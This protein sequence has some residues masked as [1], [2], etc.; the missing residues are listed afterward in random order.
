MKLHNLVRTLFLAVLVAAPAACSH[1]TVPST[2]FAPSASHVAGLHAR[3]TRAAQ[4]PNTAS[5]VHL[6]MV[7]NYSLKNVNAETGVVD[8]V[9]G[10]QYAAKPKS[11]YNTAYIPYSVD[12]YTH[13]VS[14]YRQNHPDWLEYKCDRKSP[15]FE[16]G[17]NN[18]P[19]DFTNPAVQAYQYQT[20]VDPQLAEGYG[21]IAIDTISLTNDWKQCGHFST[22]GAWVAQFTGGENDA[23]FRSAILSWEA[24]IYAHVHAQS[25]TATM[26]VNYS[27]EGGVSR[28][29]NL[30]L[31]TTTDMVFDERGFTNWGAKRNVTRPGEWR[32]IVD[33]IAY[34]ESK[35]GCYMTNAEEPGQNGAITP[36][37][38]QWVIANYLLVKNDCTYMYMTGY[39]GKAQGYGVLLTFPEYKIAIGSATGAMKASQGAYSRSFT[40][41]I[42]I[43][44]PSG[45]TVTF[46]LPAGT[47]KTVDGI[48][49]GPSV[50]LG[51]STGL[52]LL[53]T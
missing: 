15:A 33:G 50:T 11:V 26:Q 19:L 40:N 53:S 39:N 25:P 47:Y 9:W 32:T 13:S 16:F 44:N 10:S 21:G 5:N 41:G 37:E 12:N 6:E 52:V 3:G 31:M 36:Q 20:W 24:N 4:F 45:S 34:V 48:V 51:P 14:W 2:A 28:A 1:A 42:A 27:Y 43:V 38:R 30:Q 35:G 17:A 7:F 23:A 22:A 8:M 29:E 18:A 49:E 46:N